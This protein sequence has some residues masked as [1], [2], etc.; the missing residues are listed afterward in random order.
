MCFYLTIAVPPHHAAGVAALVPRSL[1][2]AAQSNRSIESQLGGRYAMFTLTSYGCSCSLYSGVDCP[3]GSADIRPKL[4]EKYA[5]K[6]WSPAKTE[7]AVESAMSRHVDT[8]AQRLRAELLADIVHRSG[9]LLMIIHH[10][11]GNVEDEVVP[12]HGRYSI[13][14]TAL[15]EHRAEIRV[16]SLY[17]VISASTMHGTDRH[18]TGEAQESR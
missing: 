11:D 8:P 13:E 6:G 16:D 14:E 2:L 10:Y 4:R 15:R 7:R 5:K 18:V 3:V 17:K 1:H 12:V 9:T